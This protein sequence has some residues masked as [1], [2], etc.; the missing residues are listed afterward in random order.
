MT[1][2]KFIKWE[3]DGFL[4]I[5]SLDNPPENYLINPKFVEIQQLKEWLSNDIRALIITGT[6]RHFSA[7]ADIQSIVAQTNEPEKLKKSMI[8]GNLVLDYISQLEI[9]VLASISG[10]CFGGGLEIALAADIR[11]F[12][13][14][15][16][17]AFPEINHDLMPALGGLKR[18]K[19]I[20]GQKTSMEILLSGD[21]FNAGKA[22]ELKIA[23]LVIDSKDCLDFSKQ[24]MN[25]L[26][27]DRSPKVIQYIMRSF[28]N[29]EL[30]E[31]DVAMLKDVEMF[32]EL[33]NDFAVKS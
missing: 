13:N 24:F 22:L 2:S 19:K 8:K 3:K 18:L 17:F 9:P 26:I 33:A 27:K 30:A 28:R 25:G 10:V 11:I 21:I 32:C 20:C 31:T 5:L 29:A 23:D 7:G 1:D 15:S 6:G 14:R 12:T 4:G 16:M